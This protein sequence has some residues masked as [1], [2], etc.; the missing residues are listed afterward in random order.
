MVLSIQRENDKWDTT[1]NEIQN[2][3]ERLYNIL[4]DAKKQKSKERTGQ[5]WASVL[6]VDISNQ[7]DILVGIA[8]II[9][10]IDQTKKSILQIEDVDHG[11]LLE[12]FPNIE[13][14]F[15]NLNFSQLWEQ[16]QQYLDETTM[17]SLRVCSDTLSNKMG[18]KNISED[19]LA[20]LQKD[21]DELLNEVLNSDLDPELKIILVENLEAIRHSLVSYRIN[22]IDGVRQALEKSLGAALIHSRLREEFLSENPNEEVKKFRKLL[23]SIANFVTEALISV[24]LE[25]GIKAILLSAGN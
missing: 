5:I 22:G 6:G 9:H 2:P 25:T 13:K 10:L 8:D 12:R 23:A 3:A 15:S 20:D 18:Y 1:M 24:A 7:G 19:I 17:Y 4:Q 11:L 16:N 21:T 14:V